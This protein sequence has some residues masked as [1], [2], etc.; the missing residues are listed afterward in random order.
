MTATGPCWS[1]GLAPGGSFGLRRG[2]SRG[3]RSPPPSRRAGRVG[4]SCGPRWGS[5]LGS[6][7]ILALPRDL[8]EVSSP[9]WAQRPHLKNG[10]SDNH[11][12]AQAPGAGTHTHRGASSSGERSAASVSLLFLPFLVTL[13]MQGETRS[14]HLHLPPSPWGPFCHT[15]TRSSGLPLPQAPCGQ[16]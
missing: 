4:V 6:G 10:Y 3:L 9:L 11:G 13:H 1:C 16:F 8:R 2:C 14:L 12:L 7:F 15:R 5:R